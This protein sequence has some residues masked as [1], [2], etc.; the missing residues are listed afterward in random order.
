MR[1]L[2]LAGAALALLCCA[3]PAA[4]QEAQGF[5]P[6]VERAVQTALPHMIA[7]RRDIHQNPELGNQEV[8][9]G[10]LVAQ[11]LRRLRFDEVR[12]GVARTGVVGVL[13]G[14]KPG[15]TIAV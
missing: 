9:T 5:S 7:W 10:R 8:R 3:A 6:A 13:R 11:H 4:A 1:V 2:N 15:P 12:T 14:G